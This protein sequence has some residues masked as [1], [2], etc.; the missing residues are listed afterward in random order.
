MRPGVLYDG[1][2]LDDELFKLWGKFKSGVRILVLSDSC[3]SGTILTADFG[4][5][6]RTHRKQR[7]AKGKKVKAS[8]LLISACQDNEK[9]YE[10]RTNSV[11]VAELKRVWNKGRFSGD[12]KAFCERIR[13]NMSTSQTPNLYTIGTKTAAFQSQSPFTI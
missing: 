3:H 9:A 7:K 6:A 12:Y 8:V 1:L 13:R 4:E 10:D 5:L 2:L 11:F